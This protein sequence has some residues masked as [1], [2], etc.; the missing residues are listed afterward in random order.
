MPL[1][2]AVPAETFSVT[3]GLRSSRRWWPA[4]CRRTGA[5]RVRQPRAEVEHERTGRQ[6]AAAGHPGSS[7]PPV[8][9]VMLPTAPLPLSVPVALTVTSAGTQRAV[10]HQD[11]AVDQ[12]GPGICLGGGK[13]FG[14][15]A[16]LGHGDRVAVLADVPSQLA[17]AVVHSDGQRGSCRG[18]RRCRRR[19]RCPSGRRY[20]PSGPARGRTV[21]RRRCSS[22]PG[23]KSSW[24][25][26]QPPLRMMPP[27][28]SMVPPVMA[29]QT[30]PR[31]WPEDR[32]SKRCGAA[33]AGVAAKRQ[34]AAARLPED[35]VAGQ[36][37]SPRWCPAKCWR[38]R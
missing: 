18:S 31:L 13:H 24:P 17:G 12:G 3:N 26:R 2:Q 32:Q 21:P 34:D 25:L 20:T 10:D 35:A 14:A 38:R 29:T 37:S 27:S 1:P 11:A 7:V 9:M 15:R 30:A 5:E 28:M 22:R 6:G 33:V 8:R 23:C 16:G 36:P 19:C 4:G